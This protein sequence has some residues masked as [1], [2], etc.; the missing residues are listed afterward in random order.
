MV[1]LWIQE[2]DIGLD[3]RSSIRAP[4]TLTKLQLNAGQFPDKGCWTASDDVK[5]SSAISSQD[6][7]NQ[8]YAVQLAHQKLR[9]DC[10]Y[11]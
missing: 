8:S 5:L 6:I 11:R 3:L 1:D 10:K 2:E 4:D 9:N 7:L